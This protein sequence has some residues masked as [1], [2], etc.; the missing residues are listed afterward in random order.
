MLDDLI[1]F[2]LLCIVSH[3]TRYKTSPVILKPSMHML[4]TAVSAALAGLWFWS[5][6]ANA[7][8][9]GGE[10]V[11]R[12]DLRAM[13]TAPSNNWSSTTTIS[14]PGSPSFTNETQRWTLFDQPTYS[15]V[16]SV[17]SETDLVTVVSELN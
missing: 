9:L 11:G 16:I 1:Y 5:T 14:F 15:A 8:A 3:Q 6:P 12:V 10:L 4:Y 2:S 17:G 7:A 13:L